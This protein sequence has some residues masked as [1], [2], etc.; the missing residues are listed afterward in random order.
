MTKT[1]PE[2]ATA[3][4]WRGPDARERIEW[5]L[6]E[7]EV[8]AWQAARATAA[9]MAAMADVLAEAER[10]PEVFVVVDGEPTPTDLKIA[11]D[12]AIADLAVRL[13]LAEGAVALLAHQA[14]TIRSRAP[15]TW[16]LFRDGGISAA[17]AR[18]L[19]DTLD[20]MPTVSVSDAALDD[21]AVDIARLAPARFG[22]RLRV[23]R[24]RLH[25]RALEE[26]H[27]E[28]ADGR[29]VVRE[30]GH[31]GMAWLGFELPAPPRCRRPG[32]ASTSPHGTWPTGR[33]N[34][35]PSTNCGRMSAPTCSPAE[36]SPRR[37]HG[38]PSASWC[39]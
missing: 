19:A 23:L 34:V 10:H 17:N 30:D 25:P 3:A 21:R 14:A 37:R 26:R 8:A 18:R 16:E 9:Q 13:S 39:R 22:E 33:T 28:A 15:R 35:A 12:A 4:L 1:A 27:R 5:R 2:S 7:A 11:H 36:T 20:G 31:D 6:A 24:E 32:S 38:S 29:R